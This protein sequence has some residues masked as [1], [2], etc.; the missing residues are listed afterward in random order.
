MMLNQEQQW[1]KNIIYP[2]MISAL[3][4]PLCMFSKIYLSLDLDVTSVSFLLVPDNWVVKREFCG[5]LILCPV[6]L[7]Y[8]INGG[9]NDAAAALKGDS[10]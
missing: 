9:N 7:G 2:C 5:C 1:C 6:C 10:L 4:G 3:D 8:G